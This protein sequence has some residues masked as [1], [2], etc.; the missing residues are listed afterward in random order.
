M[1]Q[2]GYPEIASSTFAAVVTKTELASDGHAYV[3]VKIRGANGKD[4]EAFYEL[5]SRAA[6]EDQ[7]SRGQA[8]PGAVLYAER[9]EG[10]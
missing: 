10:L 1:V 4:I 2:G 6:V 7:R 5:V 8:R 9:R 3:A